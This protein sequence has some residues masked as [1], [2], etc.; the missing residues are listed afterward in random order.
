M[1]QDL[2]EIV[3]GA[4]AGGLG[5]G[6]AAAVGE[7]LAGEHA[8]FEHALQTAVLA[9]QVADLPATH[10]HVAG[11][12]VDVRPDVAVQGAHE[13]LAEAHDL[14]VGLAGGIEVG[15]ALTAADGQAGEAV[16]E[17]LLKAQELDDAGIHVG[18]ET[19]AA[20]VGADGAVE[21]AAI[22]DIG[23]IIAVVVHPHDPE[24][25]HPLRLHD[26]VEQVG[27]LILGMLVYHG[28]D[29]GQDLLHGLHELGLVAVLL[30]D[31]FDHACDIGIHW[32]HS[33]SILQSR[34]DN[35]PPILHLLPY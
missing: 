31:I 7:A 12:H 33:S 17:D 26:P 32:N 29:G 8:V 15:A 22:A 27:L 34:Q 20:L 16:L 28:G 1:S 18:L 6:Q 14:R 21:L 11:G 9:V 10:A 5:T 2:L 13:A 30:L 25:E 35:A 19:D 3:H 23:M 24:G 4:V